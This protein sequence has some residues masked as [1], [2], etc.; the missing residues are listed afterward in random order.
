MMVGQK[1]SKNVEYFNYLGSVITKGA[2]W[3]REVKSWITMVKA[4]LR[5]EKIFSAAN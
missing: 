1:Q 4:A 5:K 2:R 3:I